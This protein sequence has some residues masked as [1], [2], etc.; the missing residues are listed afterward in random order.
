MNLFIIL[1]SLEYKHDL[2]MQ[3]QTNKT[4]VLQFQ[5]GNK[6]ALAELVKRWHKTFC[7]KAYWLTKDAD[8]S[9]DIAQD[10]WRT[11]MDKIPNLK[12]PNSFGPWA[13]RIVYRK[14]LDGLRTKA[15]EREK[16]QVYYNEQDLFE[17]EY[18]EKEVLKKKLL[19]AIKTLPINQQT[20]LKLF[21]VEEY[22]LKEISTL[23]QISIGTTKSRLFHAREKLKA[24]NWHYK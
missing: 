13:L 18:D 24:N 14:S 1:T 23:L 2:L 3:N 11:I 15:K 4:L 19:K 7:S 20:V 8:V 5:S 22:S 16:Q 10:S 17:D 21:Y 12:D 9:K 6:K